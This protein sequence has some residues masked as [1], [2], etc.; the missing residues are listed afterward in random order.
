[1]R[2]PFR[3]RTNSCCK[4]TTVSHLVVARW[5]FFGYNRRMVR[6]AYWGWTWT[7]HDGCVKHQNTLQHLCGALNGTL[8]TVK[9]HSGTHWKPL[10]S[11]CGTLRH[12]EKISGV[13]SHRL[14]LNSNHSHPTH[15]DTSSDTHKV[16]HKLSTALY[17]FYSQAY[18]HIFLLYFRYIPSTLLPFLPSPL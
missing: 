18:Q 7:L 14:R 5:L 8:H 13:H 15:R 11:C 6:T 12:S 9:G 2:N 4:E 16:I 3:T 10:E 17:T 1:M